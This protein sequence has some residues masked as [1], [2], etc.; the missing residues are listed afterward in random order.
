VHHEVLREPGEVV[1]PA[2]A[3][4]PEEVDL[5]PAVVTD[6][7][8]VDRCDEHAELDVVTDPRDEGPVDEPAVAARRVA[9][10]HRVPGNVG[11]EEDLHRFEVPSRSV[12][13]PGRR[14]WRSVT[15]LHLCRPG[16]GPP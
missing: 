9:R 7:D 14:R 10:H 6:H 5:R 3:G 4:V 13:P 1:H 16:C 2:E 15:L 8:L 12:A 11:D